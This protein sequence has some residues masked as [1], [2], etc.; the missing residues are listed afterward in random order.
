MSELDILVL[1][2]L[3]VA[4]TSLVCVIIGWVV[5]ENR[6]TRHKAGDCPFGR[7]TT[8]VIKGMGCR[9]ERGWEAIWRDEECIA[10]MRRED[11]VMRKI[12]QMVEEQRGTHRQAYKET[13]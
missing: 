1:G 12:V 7:H 6:E 2:L 3:I 5:E 10:I 13:E 9:F 8:V 4:P 11:D